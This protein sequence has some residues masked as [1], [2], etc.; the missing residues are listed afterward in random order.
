MD[1]CPHLLPLCI[2]FYQLLQGRQREEDTVTIS[3]KSPTVLESKTCTAI[4]HTTQTSSETSEKPQKPSMLLEGLTGYKDGTEVHQGHSVSRGSC[5]LWW[6][7]CWTLCLFPTLLS[8]CCGR[9][10]HSLCPSLPK[11]AASQKPVVGALRSASV[12][13]SWRES[14]WP[15][16]PCVWPLSL[17]SF[18]NVC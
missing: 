1:P 16:M 12:V 18:P 9:L 10:G 14:S 6:R 15:K 17:V 2:G 13:R 8:H 11:A 4:S 5:W 7:G 3:S